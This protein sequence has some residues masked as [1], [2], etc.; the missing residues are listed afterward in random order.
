MMLIKI[1]PRA[2]M[3]SLSL[4]VFV[5]SV[6][7]RATANCIETWIDSNAD[8]EVIST[9][10]LAA[11]E[12][13]C[14]IAG[15]TLPDSLTTMT[16]LRNINFGDESGPELI[17]SIPNAGWEKLT[18]LT[19]LNLY[20]N[21]LIGSIPS[22]LGNLSE[23][24]DLSFGNNK[25]VGSIPKELGNLTSVIY[26]G[27]DNNK[28]TG[29]IPLELTNLDE[30]QNIWLHD[31]RFH[32]GLPPFRD[33][34]PDK[35]TV[36]DDYNGPIYYNFL[37]PGES[38][39]GADSTQCSLGVE[40]CNYLDLC[41]SPDEECFPIAPSLMPTKQPTKLPTL[42]PTSN[43]TLLPTFLPTLEP[44]WQPTLGPTS[45]PTIVRV[46][47]SDAE[48]VPIAIIAGS[49]TGVIALIVGFV[50]VT[51][52][53]KSAHNPSEL[54]LGPGLGQGFKVSM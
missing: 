10:L 43:P 34:G 11:E 14:S 33:E 12:P 8:E 21:K 48:S 41:C 54:F 25:L 42:L 32:G 26:M 47:A 31:N 51:R 3:L 17:G 23:L 44:T 38:C 28:L 53:R 37:A 45:Q 52:K 13:S 2:N 22:E 27:I 24:I 49:V 7:D 1:H 19:E 9:A 20:S 36:D 16:N 29:L 4:L 30:L 15:L 18:Q 39:E 46:S 50:L 35:V 40:K 6:F 5:F